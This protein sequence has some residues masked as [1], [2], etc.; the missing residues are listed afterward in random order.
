M[1]RAMLW[2]AERRSGANLQQLYE[3]GGMKV[4]SYI[5]SILYYLIPVSAAVFFFVSI[6]RYVLAKRKNKKMPGSYTPEQMK[7]RKICLIVSSVIAGIL[8][9]V[10]LAFIGLLMMAVAFM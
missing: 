5:V 1:N 4:L 6:F 2:G 7:S 9:L 10:V 3:R 8:A